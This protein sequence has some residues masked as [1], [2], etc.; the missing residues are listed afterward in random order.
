MLSCHPDIVI[1]SEDYSCAEFKILSKPIVGNK[2]CI[3][4]QIE[5]THGSAR[6]PKF[7]GKQL[8][9]IKRNFASLTGK[10]ATPLETYMARLSIRQYEEVAKNLVVIGIIRSPGPVIDSIQKRGKQTP[11]EAERRWRRA[12]E[13]LYELRC[14]RDSA[15]ELVIVRYDDLVTCSEGTIRKVLAKLDCSFDETV[16]EG[17]KHTPQYS[18]SSSIDPQKAGTGLAADLEHSTLI[19]DKPLSDMYV[20][21]FQSAI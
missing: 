3:P 14:H 9:K 19:Q 2:L 10:D 13:I 7:A 5:L 12:I 20:D 11:A 4:N 21:L 8:Q 17:Y 1:L 15:T 16:M 6:L 18:D